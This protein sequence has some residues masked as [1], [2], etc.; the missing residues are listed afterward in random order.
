MS[1]KYGS[2][3]F[4]TRHTYAGTMNF[5]HKYFKTNDINLVQ[6]VESGQLFILKEFEDFTH[7]CKYKA[8]IDVDKAENVLPF[9]QMSDKLLEGLIHETRYSEKKA[10]Y[11]TVKGRLSRFISYIDYL[12]NL[13]HFDNDVSPEIHN[14]IT[15]L[16]KL[17]TDTIAT[18]IK[19]N[20][21]V[22]DPFEK[23]IP[24]D[25]F[26]SFL[27]MIHPKS[28]NNPFKGSR[29]RNHILVSILIETGIRRGAVAKLKLSDI[30]DSND[31]YRLLTTRTP[32]D[33]TDKRLRAG[34]QKTNAHSS[35]ISSELMK[36]IKTYITTERSG[37]KASESHDFLLVS[38]K[39]V[40]AGDPLSLNMV[41]SVIDKLSNALGFHITPHLIRHKWNE[42]FHTRALA[43]GY[44]SQQIEDIRKYAMG[45]TE[46]S[47]MGQIY[48]K[49][50][51]AV[52]VHE[53]SVERSSDFMPEAGA[54]KKGI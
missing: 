31:N 20:A 23:A 2:K 33:K 51:N 4:N 12:Y 39:G 37:Y 18:E 6:R 14:K 48:N 34:A 15:E 30:K 13:F 21:S 5:L 50:I 42:I 8:D 19:N 52:I 27:E 3:S 53:L 41:S 47:K 46:D 22:V 24:D 38:E 43:A 1:E 10:G 11:Q 17:V 35:A 36:R 45:W 28:L 32:D 16:R 9:G 49:F 54:D 40:T 7:H 29:F 26:V 44:T 25:I